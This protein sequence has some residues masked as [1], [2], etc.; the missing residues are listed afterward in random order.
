MCC[1]THLRLHRYDYASNMARRLARL[2]LVAAAAAASVLLLGWI[3]WDVCDPAALPYGVQPNTAAG[4]LQQLCDY[5][6][7]AAP[8]P[9]QPH[10][11]LE[12]ATATRHG[13]T[14]SQQH[15][16]DH[17][18]SG[19][20][21]AAGGRAG[22]GTGI[23]GGGGGSGGGGGV[24]TLALSGPWGPGWSLRNANGSVA[25]LTAEV[26]GYPLQVGLG[27]RAAVGCDGTYRCQHAAVSC[28]C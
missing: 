10:Q 19:C 23:D 4:L 18:G 12:T 7:G 3:A 6:M 13:S 17:A 24:H 1:N 28:R 5:A 2:P 11:E 20:G 15:E 21:G 9:L 8:P 25:G 26:P 16:S 27:W 22:R 14:H